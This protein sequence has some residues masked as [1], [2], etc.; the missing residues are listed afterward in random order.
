MLPAQRK[1]A[2]A[3]VTLQWHT[4]VSYAAFIDGPDVAAFVVG[5]TTHVL[6]LGPHAVRSPADRM[7]SP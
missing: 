5:E 1:G 7:F 2:A 6:N 4:P 3:M